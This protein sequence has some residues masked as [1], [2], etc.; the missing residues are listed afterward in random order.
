M[1]KPL[2]PIDLINVLRG[3]AGPFMADEP[4][5]TPPLPPEPFWRRFNKIPWIFKRRSALD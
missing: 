4:R 1:A 3:P 2:H 5:E